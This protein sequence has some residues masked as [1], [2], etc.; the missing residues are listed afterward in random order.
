MATVCVPGGAGV[1]GSVAV[2]DRP[3]PVRGRSLV[4]AIL[5]LVLVS[6]TGAGE[7]PSATPVALDPR[8]DGEVLLRAGFG[9][10]LAIVELPDVTPVPLRMPNYERMLG[11]FFDPE[12]NVVAVVA[13]PGGR[14]GLYR[15]ARDAAPVPIGPTLPYADAYSAAGGSV[16]ATGCGSEPFARVLDLDAPDRWHPVEAGCGATLS[17]DAAWVA[18]SPDGVQVLRAPVG[19]GRAPL[20]V[21]EIG[22]LPVPA[23]LEEEARFV[24]PV[25]WGDAGEQAVLVA[26]DGWQ[27]AAVTDPVPTVDPLGDHGA[28][29]PFAILD[30]QPA[31]SLLAVASSTTVGGVVRLLEPAGG[32]R[33]AAMFGAPATGAL[34]SPDGRALLATSNSTWAVVAPDGTWLW[35]RLVDR[36]QEPLDW[37][38]PA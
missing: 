17:P 29:P 14:V 2:H 12:G 21:F 22:D 25:A 20:Q 15:V 16:L 24:G 9:N 6:C 26:G 10:A 8:V 18:W 34:W 11:G 23:T 35:S 33:V 19:G 36:G 30:W 31:G 5:M 27:G 37:W 7:A 3:A 32:S 4:L 38:A 13:E 1:S 28:G